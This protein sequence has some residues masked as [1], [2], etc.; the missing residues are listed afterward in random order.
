MTTVSVLPTSSG[1]A[2]WGRQSLRAARAAAEQRL[3]TLL[4]R[5]DFDWGLL[6]GETSTSGERA[7]LRPAP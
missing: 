2:Q 5:D 6:A 3:V 1:L 7:R 4:D